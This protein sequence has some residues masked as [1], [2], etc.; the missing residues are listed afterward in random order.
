[1]RANTGRSKG[2]HVNLAG[3]KAGTIQTTSDEFCFS[4]SSYGRNIGTVSIRK[5][6]ATTAV[7][8]DLR[9]AVQTMVAM[10]TME[11]LGLSI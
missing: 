2:K 8:K 3:C 1:M 6:E 4:I 9:L 7:V 5:S 11:E 10:T